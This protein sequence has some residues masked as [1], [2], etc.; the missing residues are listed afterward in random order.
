MKV[1]IKKG[2]DITLKEWG[3]MNSERIKEY[4]KGT[5][6]FSK[7]Y[8]G[9]SNFFFLKENNKIIAWGFLRPVEM[10]F[11]DEKYNI[12]AMGGIMVIGEMKRQGYGAILIK[13][14]IKFS[15]K[16]NKTILGFCG[17]SRVKFYKKVGLNIAKDLSI[18]IEMENPKTK[19]R[20]P[21]ID[22]ACPGI[23][24]EGKDKFVTEVSRGKG[25]ATY[26]MPDIKEP[27]F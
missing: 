3:L 6:P 16:T 7:K 18:R 2:K 12:F 17:E 20:I 13:E 21:D 4:G 19:K 5:N 8:H 9:K 23:Y 26:W 24:F 15:K 25:I 22:G 11:N 27:H 1:E 14:M 10:V